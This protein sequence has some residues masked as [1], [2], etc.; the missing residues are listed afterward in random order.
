MR[1]HCHRS[2]LEAHAPNLLRMAREQQSGARPDRETASRSSSAAAK[3][4]KSAHPAS[5]AD[6]SSSSSPARARKHRSQCSDCQLPAG[7]CVW[8]PEVLS[9]VEATDY[10]DLHLF[11]KHAYYPDSYCLPPFV[12]ASIGSAFIVHD[13][14]PEP[15]DLSTPALWS[16]P[17]SQLLCDGSGVVLVHSCILI[18]AHY[19]GDAALLSRSEQVMMARLR[20]DEDQQCEAWL[21]LCHAVR[22]GMRQLKYLCMHVL[23][24][25]DAIV[26]DRDWRTMDGVAEQSAEA[27]L[28]LLQ[29]AVSKYRTE[30]RKNE[31]RDNP[32]PKREPIG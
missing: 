14:L 7:S 23:T 4:R 10:Q 32:A 12:P 26:E 19:A 2:L 9:D 17:A 24:E 20:A 31:G 22:Y 5:A 18:C 28:D 29:L 15:V 3:R 30:R 27:L 21:Y 6:S 13:T 1:F 16:L 8:L 25:W 11:L